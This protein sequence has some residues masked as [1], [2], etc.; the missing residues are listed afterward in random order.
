MAATRTGRGGTGRPRRG[1]QSPE[2]RAAPAWET[3]DEAE[4]WAKVVYYGDPGTG[5]TTALAS[6]ARRG[7]ILFVNAESGLKATPLR[8]LGI[9]TDPDHIEKTRIEGFEDAEAL[10]WDLRRRFRR[11]PQVLLGVCVDSITE[12][13]QVFMQEGLSEA[14]RA[15][16][17]RG[18]ERDTFLTEGD[19]WG[20]NN[21]KMRRF[22]RGLR[23]LPC[24]VGFSALAR[25]DEDEQGVVQ[26]RPA[27]GPKV[28]NELIAHCDISIA[29][30]AAPIRR[31]SDRSRGAVYWGYTQRHTKYSG[32]D[33]F[34]ILPLQFPFP[35]MDRI[36]DYLRGDLTAETDPEVAA[37]QDREVRK[38]KS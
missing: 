27:L 15:A 4:D 2:R 26:Y 6:L 1:I 28:A 33:R 9:P 5:K 31:R 11:N 16:A 17:R 25:R 36:V 20:R 3:L 14:V 32:K 35:S 23:D 38:E 37:F 19:D 34:G 10:L 18:V 8:R 13:E 12:I 24:H 21:A 22:I 29:M 30:Q 7:K